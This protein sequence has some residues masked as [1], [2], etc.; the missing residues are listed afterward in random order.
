ML[1]DWD[2]L[3]NCICCAFVGAAF[4]LIIHEVLMDFRE[5][6]EEREKHTFSDGKWR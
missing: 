4:P 2:T 5:R 1:F 3:V 6:R